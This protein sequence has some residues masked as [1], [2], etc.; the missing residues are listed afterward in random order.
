VD[1]GVNLDEQIG[2]DAADIELQMKRTELLQWKP[3]PTL[4]YSKVGYNSVQ[5]RTT[6]CYLTSCTV[7]CY[8]TSVLWRS[9]YR[10]AGCSSIWCVR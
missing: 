9:M 5:L 7:G 6:A 3:E 2:L 10:I 8:L 4:A 1:V